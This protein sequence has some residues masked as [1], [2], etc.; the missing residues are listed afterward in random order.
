MQSVPPVL[1]KVIPEEL[2]VSQGQVLQQMR[3]K[4]LVV[5]RLHWVFELELGKLLTLCGKI[6]VFWEE[7]LAC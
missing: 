2:V 7:L 5:P 4:P 6:Q 3:P 1:G